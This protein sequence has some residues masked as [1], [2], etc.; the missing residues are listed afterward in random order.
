MKMARLLTVLLLLATTST[1]SAALTKTT[2]VLTSSQNPS[3]Y[4]QPV[5]FTAVVTPAP[6]NSETV[7]FKQGANVLGTGPLNGGSAMFTISTLTTG[8]TD[9]IT[10]VYGG[11][12]TYAS[13]T[14]TVVKQVVDPI[15]TST[16]VAS[17]LNPSTYGQSVTFT[18]TVSSGGSGTIT[19]NVGFYNGSA[20]L[21]TGALSGGQAS[22]TTTKLQL[23]AGTDSIT[24]VY[25]GST[26]FATS[27]SG[28]L[29]Q[30][31]TST[32]GATPTKDYIDV[33]AESL[34]LRADGELHGSGR[35]RRGAAAGVR[36]RGHGY[37]QARIE[38][39]WNG[40]VER[41]LGYFYDLDA[42]GGWDGQHHGG[43]RR[44]LDLRHQ[45][46]D[47]CETGG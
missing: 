45:H 47:G 31:V 33:F 11:D 30:K 32:G 16:S 46:V 26:T 12:S 43:V 20:S 2:T 18:A 17:S 7:T 35:C 21:G 42:G 44:R 6:P 41:R 28:V 10:A 34:D 25:K 36:E 13:S 4:E 37:L 19:G 8:G 3:I 24:A 29:S 14:S 9:N 39:D 22:Y 23:P 5:T 40:K 27:T 15:P 1:L 38:H